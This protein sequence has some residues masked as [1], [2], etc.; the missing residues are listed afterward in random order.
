MWTIVHTRGIQPVLRGDV[1]DGEHNAMNVNRWVPRVD[2]RVARRVLAAILV[3]SGTWTL[4]GRTV[5]RET[6]RKA[7]LPPADLIIVNARIWTGASSTSDN[8]TGITEPTALGVIG[9]SIVVVG[10]D[11]SVRSRIGPSTKV[12]DAK[13]RRVIPG[14]TDSH[15][16]IIGGGLQFGRL[17]LRDVRNRQEFVW[18]VKE[19]ADGKKPGQWVLGGRWSVESWAQ[20][21]SPKRG[22]LD[23]VTGAVPVF[24][25][26]MDGHQAV[27]NSAALRLAG[28][29]AS[30]PRDPMGGEIDRDPR[31]GEPTGVLKESAMEL[32]RRLIPKPSL[33]QRYEALGRAM[34]HA[35]SL[36]ITSVHNM[37]SPEDLDVFRLADRKKSLT[38]RITAYLQTSDW[39][40]NLDGVAKTDLNHGMVRLVGFKGYMDGSLGS[41][42]AYMRE[43]FSDA[44]QE[45][46]YPRGQLSA[47][48]A[49]QGSFLEQVQLVHQRGLQM[50]VHAIG[51][52]ANHLLLNAYEAA[53]A[54]RRGGPQHRI[55]HAQHLHLA[56]IERF[57]KIGVVASMQPFHKADDGRYAEKALGKKRL[58]GSYAFRQLLDAGALVCFGSD[59]PVVT[60]NPFAGVDSAVNAVT[61]AGDVWLASHSITVEEALRAYTVAP[62]RAIGRQDKV[63]TLEAG[64]LADI[65]MLMSDPL[66]IPPRQIGDVKVALTIVGGRVVYS[67]AP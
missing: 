15:T 11:D 25:S 33:Q 9:N 53:V 64:K 30:G 6:A 42:T 48:A 19:A 65:V 43:P 52:E 14:I 51:D 4:P 18:A 5:G 41:R 66:T 44:T 29:D 54:G 67:A 1:R 2:M 13:Q 22:W 20:P 63:G 45:T 26:R 10:D 39:L 58:A 46:R 36:G 49:S 32:V 57:A 27:V 3:I 59:W 35:N 37:T 21:E 34:K 38:V 62:Q 28:I 56:D 8:P 50:A 17:A 23:P 40:T 31:T 16:H 12:I 24:L 55:E 7:L 61:L 47:F 60:L